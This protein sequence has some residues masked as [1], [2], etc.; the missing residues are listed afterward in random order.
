M[1]YMYPLFV[2]NFPV[3]NVHTFCAVETLSDVSFY[4]L[5]LEAFVLI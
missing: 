4:I 5:V 2:T 3:F 1:R